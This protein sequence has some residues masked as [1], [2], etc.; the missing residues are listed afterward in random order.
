[1]RRKIIGILMLCI[2]LIMLFYALQLTYYY[3]FKTEVVFAFM[4]PNWLLLTYVL[5]ATW[6]FFVDLKLLKN[7][8]TIQKGLLL[9]LA[10]KLALFF[11]E[12]WLF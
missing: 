1:M 5:V 11:V 6:G 9:D 10:P 8:L 4:L 3:N 7:K 2:N 12:Y